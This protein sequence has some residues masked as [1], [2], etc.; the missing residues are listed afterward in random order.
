MHNCIDLNL[1]IH[2]FKEG[3]DVNL[4]GTTPH[5]KISLNE[6]NNDLISLLATLNVTIGFAEL[7]YTAPHSFT[8]IHTDCL[9]G[10]YIKLNYVFGGEDSC[11]Y[12]WKPKSNVPNSPLKTPINSFYIRYKKT[13]VEL[14]EKKSVKFPSIIQAGIPHNVENFKEPRYCL[15]LVLKNQNDNRLTMTESIE[16]FKEYL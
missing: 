12:W 10:D 9:G 13:E 8:G 2:P 7:F 1:N 5:T 14:I 16:I 6:I 11:M 15:S 4:Y 3:I